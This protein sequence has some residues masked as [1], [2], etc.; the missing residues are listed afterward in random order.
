MN[1]NTGLEM[2]T[3]EKL[4]IQSQLCDALEHYVVIRGVAA[5]IYRTH[6]FRPNNFPTIY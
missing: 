6:I 3:S 2:P 4:K 1:W 5:S